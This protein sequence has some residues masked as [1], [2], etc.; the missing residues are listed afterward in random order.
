MVTSNTRPIDF[1]TF[2]DSDGEPV[3][4]NRRNLTQMT[5]L[6]FSFEVYLAPR[7]RFAV[8]GNQ[9][10]YYNPRQGRDHVSPD[11]YVALDVEPGI[12]QKWQTWLEGG[13]FPD[14]VF[15]ITSESTEKEDLGSKVDL[16]ARLGA[17]EYYVYDPEQILRPPL[18]AY[19][20]RGASLVE[21]P[22]STPPG[23]FSPALGAELRVVD[24]WLR[25]IDPATGDAVPVP[26]EDHIARLAAEQAL[27]ASEAALRAAGI[28]LMQARAQAEEARAQAEEARAQAEEALEQAR[29]EAQGRLAAE[30]QLRR[31][32]EALEELQ[33][34]QGDPSDR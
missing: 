7:R 1:S 28:H 34:R 26:E 32:Q 24:Q 8:G 10:I 12:R 9:F 19:H 11:V 14:V 15:E 29:R 25:V 22:L 5:D 27:A 6:I 2:P 20:R 18:R 21:Q 31:L 4:E 17:D 33:R 16:Y 13:R 23:I 3:A 30:E